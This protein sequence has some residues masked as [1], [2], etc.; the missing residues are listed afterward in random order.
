M[1]LAIASFLFTVL[2]ISQTVFPT[3]DNVAFST[4]PLDASTMQRKVDVGRLREF[5]RD[6]RTRF[7]NMYGKRDLLLASWSNHKSRLLQNVFYKAFFED[8][9]ILLAAIGGSAT[10]GSQVGNANS[11]PFLLGHWLQKALNV[12]Q[13]SATV[14][15]LNAAIGSTNSAWA[16]TVMPK[17][18]GRKADILLW[19]YALNDETFHSEGRVQAIELFLR[20][21]LILFGPN[22][23]IGFAYLYDRPLGRWPP[24]CSVQFCQEGVLK[25]YAEYGYEMTAISACEHIRHHNFS[26]ETILADGHHP[27]QFGHQLVADMLAY[28]YLEVLDLILDGIAVDAIIPP[29]VQ[30][31]TSICEGKVLDVLNNASTFAP[32]V[33][34]TPWFG[35]ISDGAF[36]ICPSTD[37]E[38]VDEKAVLFGAQDPG[39]KDRKFAWE[40]PKC[41]DGGI[42]YEITRRYNLF[43]LQTKNKGSNL[44]PYELMP[45]PEVKVNG[46]PI[47]HVP[48]PANVMAKGEMTPG[49]WYLLNPPQPPFILDLCMRDDWPSPVM[50]EEMLF[51]LP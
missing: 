7:E 47:R 9:N 43:G 27:N 42:K 5:I 24:P 20:R 41:R 30:Q 50:S 31:I 39:R 48:D 23:S 19:E 40:I 21:A 14:T 49:L 16:A 51:V 35:E 13:S 29:S 37:K 26:K 6:E 2:Y 34:H 15:V 44:A 17:Q 22:V 25:R 12:S 18:I 28:K 10:A 36:L 8:R 4:F 46:V 33:N 45:V 11:F 32:R 3:T 1:M 38:C